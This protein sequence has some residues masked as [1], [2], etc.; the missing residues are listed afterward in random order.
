MK[1]VIKL[2]FFSFRLIFATTQPSAQES[3][4]T[5]IDSSSTKSSA[6]ISAGTEKPA[7]ARYTAAAGTE[8][9]PEYI[10]PMR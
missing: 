8:T 1:T 3:V 7:T 6:P 2:L 4:R 9:T 10:S 5:N